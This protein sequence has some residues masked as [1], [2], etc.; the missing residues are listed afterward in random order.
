M[1]YTGVTRRASD[2]L[3]VQKATTAQKMD[4]L[5]AMRDLCEP[6]LGIL[7]EG[8]SLSRF[9]ELLHEGWLLKRSVV[10]TIS[11]DVIDEYYDRAR[12]A[13][14]IGGKLLGAGGG[15]FLLF[16][17]EKQKPW[18]DKTG[19]E[20][21]PGTPLPLRTPGEQGHLHFRRLLKNSPQRK[22]EG[23]RE[24]RREGIL[25]LVGQTFQTAVPLLSVV[26]SAVNP[27]RLLRRPSR[28]R[29]GD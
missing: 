26:Y 7:R 20:R 1:F 11:N 17:V 3:E 23:R 24:R 8:R 10:G 14:A 29:P 19:P 9:G 21:P 2:I 4:V 25:C 12:H 16:Y 6:A 18:E 15:G 5:T 22:G 28:K 13:G 27:L